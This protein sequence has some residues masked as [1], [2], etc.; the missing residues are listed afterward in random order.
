MAKLSKI[1][2]VDDSFTV[3]MYDNGFMIEISGR[4][5][6]D[7]WATSKI[8]CNTIDELFEIIGEVSEMERS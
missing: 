5:L 8:L 7:D 2:T 3:H 1:K 6:N 4:N